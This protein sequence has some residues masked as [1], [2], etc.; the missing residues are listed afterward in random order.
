MTNAVQTAPAHLIRVTDASAGR[1]EEEMA[2]PQSLV[3][4]PADA[5]PY[6]RD[7]EG[8]PTVNPL[9]VPLVEVAGGMMTT[10]NFPDLLRQGVRFDA[11]TAYNGVPVTWPHFVAEE[12]SNKPQEEY[13]RDA[14]LGIAPEVSEGQPYPEA[15]VNL[16]DGVVVPNVKRGFRITITEEMRR[17]DQLGK[18][19]QLAQE[20]GR[21]LRVTEE[22]AVYSVL[23][24][25]ANY[26][27]SEAAGDNDE[28]ANTQTLTFSADALVAAWN[29]LTTMKDRKSGTY[30]GVRPDTLIVAPK[31]VWAVK[32]LIQGRTTLRVGTAATQ[33]VYGT[34]DANP[35]FDLVDTVIVSPFLGSEYEWVLLERARPIKFQRVAPV[36]VLPARY[37]EERDTWVFRARTWFGVGMV[38]DRFA[39][40]SDSVTKPAVN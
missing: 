8:R 24:T 22:Y 30:L 32:Q 33:E 25:A 38:D 17:F 6:P 20:A 29:V 26:V 18:V 3:S 21:A 40:F 9:Q 12:S 5:L 14:A 16:D 19:R 28:G 34:G 31:L 1:F 23:T 7:V 13:L 37:D 39:F 11:F 15:A 2:W 35:F 10:R 27:R 4:V 36:E